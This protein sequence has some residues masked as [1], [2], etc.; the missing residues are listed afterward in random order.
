MVREFVTAIP[1]Q[2]PHQSLQQS[3]EG[4]LYHRD[5]TS[6][7]SIQSRDTMGAICRTHNDWRKATSCSF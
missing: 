5:Q 4:S 2:R 7:S 6:G 1:G 3:L